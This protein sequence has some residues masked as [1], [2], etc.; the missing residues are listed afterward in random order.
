MSKN[1]DK[2]SITPLVLEFSQTSKLL[3]AGYLSFALESNHQTPYKPVLV[4]NFETLSDSCHQ[5]LKYCTMFSEHL[6]KFK[7]LSRTLLNVDFCSVFRRSSAT[8]SNKLLGEAGF[9]NIGQVE[10]LSP[11]K[12]HQNKIKFAISEKQNSKTNFTFK[13]IKTEYTQKRGGRGK[14]QQYL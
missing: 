9:S 12:L 3:Y 11:L 4:L 10:Y 14:K 2:S 6:I 5:M 1:Q 7:N 8:T 13:P